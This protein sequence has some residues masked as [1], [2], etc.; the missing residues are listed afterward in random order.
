MEEFSRFNSSTEDAVIMVI[1]VLRVNTDTAGI[2]G[3]KK[4]LVGNK[5][6]I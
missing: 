5:K 6:V 1:D 2:K 4:V 3:V